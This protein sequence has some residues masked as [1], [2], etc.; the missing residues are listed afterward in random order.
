MVTF[1]VKDL[2]KILNDVP[3]DKTYSICLQ[4]G[5]IIYQHDESTDSFLITS[6]NIYKTKRDITKVIVHN[7]HIELHQENVHYTNDKETKHY[8]IIDFI[9]INQIKKITYNDK[10]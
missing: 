4:D 7:G 2:N 5:I 8:T 1:S 3:E 6:G 9:P 10:K